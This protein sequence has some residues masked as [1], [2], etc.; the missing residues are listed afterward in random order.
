MGSWSAPLI[1]EDLASLIDMTEAL[2]R[3][4]LVRQRIHPI[5]LL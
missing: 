1:A 3:L 2:T 5:I 4:K